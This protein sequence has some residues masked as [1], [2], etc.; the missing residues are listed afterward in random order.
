MINLLS[1]IHFPK[2]FTPN[3]SPYKRLDH[4]TL[5]WPFTLSTAFCPQRLGDF[6]DAQLGLVS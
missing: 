1:S 2:Y 4:Y 3:Q 5:K 6:T